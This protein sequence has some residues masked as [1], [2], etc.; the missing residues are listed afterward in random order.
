MVYTVPR[1]FHHFIDVFTTI[2]QDNDEEEPLESDSGNA[3]IEY[4]KLNPEQALIQAIE[5]LHLL[6]DL[7]EA[8]F[9]NHEHS[10]LQ[11]RTMKK[12]RQLA[13]LY[14]RERDKQTMNYVLDV[15]FEELARNLMT[16]KQ[17]NLITE[18]GKPWSDIMRKPVRAAALAIKSYQYHMSKQTEQLN[19]A[20][21]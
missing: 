13:E 19:L 21:I 9:V 12:A 5:N 7:I 8:H 18:A 15:Q 1:L 11:Q 10:H 2:W 3:E 20:P 17:C 6:A 16:L 14:A 4:R